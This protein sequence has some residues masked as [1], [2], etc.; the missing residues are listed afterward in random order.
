[1]DTS[2]LTK[3]IDDLIQ[4]KVENA[5]LKHKTP[6]VN[7]EITCTKEMLDE[8]VELKM[9]IKEF[10]RELDD[11]TSRIETLEEQCKQYRYHIEHYANSYLNINIDEMMTNVEEDSIHSDDEKE[12]VV[13]VTSSTKSIKNVI[14]NTNETKDKDRVTYMR[15]YMRE[16][17]KKNK[18]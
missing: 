2:F 1:M 15:E 13:S 16:R 12:T 18:K 14:V 3:L 6:H 7:N 11:K 5:L 17:R 8:N 4:V 10:E 9:R